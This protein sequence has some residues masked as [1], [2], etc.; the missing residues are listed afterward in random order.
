MLKD[1]FPLITECVK[2]ELWLTQHTQVKQIPP[3]PP[4]R[5]PNKVQYTRHIDTSAGDEEPAVKSCI[6]RNWKAS[7]CAADITKYLRMWRPLG[8]HRRSDTVASAMAAGRNAPCSSSVLGGRRGLGGGEVVL[9]VRH[10][11]N[12]SPAGYQPA[13]WKSFSFR[14]HIHPSLECA[15]FIY[16]GLSA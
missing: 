10:L 9:M 3:H 4:K 7:L 2:T 8:K 5:N 16:F 6:I 15:P 1:G 11:W 12:A 13:L 14:L